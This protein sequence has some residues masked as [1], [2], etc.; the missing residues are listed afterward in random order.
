[1]VDDKI[2]I[3]VPENRLDLLKAYLEGALTGR[4]LLIFA[5]GYRPRK[6]I[7]IENPKEPDVVSF[8]D[9]KGYW[10]GIDAMFINRI[11]TRNVV[12]ADGHME[13]ATSNHK[14][15]QG[16]MKN[17]VDWYCATGWWNCPMFGL[18]FMF[19]TTDCGAMWHN[20]LVFKLNTTPNNDGFKQRLN[21]GK[22]C[23]L[24]IIDKIKNGTIDFDPSSDSIDI[25][26]HSM[27]HAY[28]VGIIEAL[29]A[30]SLKLKFG[31]FYV[32]APENACSAYGAFDLGIFEEVWQYGSNER[33]P[34]K[35]WEQDGIAP[36]CPVPGIDNPAMYTKT[37]HGRVNFPDHLDP[38][39]YLDCHVIVSYYW[40]FSERKKGMP[41]YVKPR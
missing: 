11:G 39:H 41:G 34:V 28:A 6:P 14:S 22:L 9:T 31:R 26:S 38:K 17:M 4:N 13:V 7:P 2:E 8:A 20:P 12:Y 33:L 36:Q 40:L 18:N 32:L 5:N 29:K 27:G 15:Q 25:V 10:A 37:N 21:A 1:M 19:T 35:S 23:G 3:R 24:D 30:S 16:F